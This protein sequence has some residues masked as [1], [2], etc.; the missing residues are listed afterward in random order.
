MEL[1]IE[2]GRAILRLHPTVAGVA[3]QILSS[4][5]LPDGQWRVE[6][7]VTGAHDWTLATLPWRGRTSLFLTARSAWPGGFRPADGAQSNGCPRALDAML[8]IDVS[9]SLSAGDFQGAMEAADN[10]VALVDFSVDRVGLVSFAGDARLDQSL[11]NNGT[12]VRT[13]ILGLETRSGT[14]LHPAIQAAQSNLVGS[15]GSV[16][17]LM[18]LLSDGIINH[19]PAVNTNLAKQE[20]A[21]A[22]AAGTRLISIAYGTDPAGTNL[23]R[24]L[25]SGPQDFYY[26]PSAA[27]LRARFTAIAASLCRDGTTNLPPWVRLDTPTHQSFF[28][29]LAVPV[30]ASAMDEDGTIVRLDVVANGQVIGSGAGTNLSFTWHPTGGGTYVLSAHATDDK[31]AVAMSP[32]ATI[33]I[34]GGP[35]VGAGPDQTVMMAGSNPVSA[36]LNGTVDDPDGLPLGRMLDIQWNVQGGPG[37]VALEPDPA[38]PA[39]AARARATFRIPGVY[40]LRL[41]VSDSLLSR[42]DEVRITVLKTNAPPVVWT[43]PS[44]TILHPDPV[45]LPGAVLDDGAPVGGVLTA[46]WGGPAGVEFMNPYVTNTFARFPGPGVYPLLL[47]AWDGMQDQ[48]GL[49]ATGRVT[50]TVLPARTPRVV[51]DRDELSVGVGG[52][53]GFFL[54]ESRVSDANPHPGTAELWLRGL[55]G[56][57]D[58]AF[59][60]WHG[61]VDPAAPSVNAAVTI[62]G[63]LIT[64]QDLGR[65]RDNGWTYQDQSHS[66]AYSRAY[67]ADVT[68][69]VRTFGSGPYMLTNF[70]KGAEVEVN[71]ASMVVFFDDGQSGNNHDFILADGNDSNDSLNFHPATPVNFGALDAAPGAVKALALA[72]DGVFIAGRFISANVP[73]RNGIARLRPGGALDAAFAPVAGAAPMGDLREGVVYQLNAMALQRDGKVILGGNFQKIEGQARTN[74]ARLLPDGKLD[75]SF[76]I[77]VDGPVH[78]LLIDGNGRIQVGGGFATVNGLVR[79]S[80]AR[81]TSTGALDGTFAPALAVNGGSIFALAVQTNGQIVVGGDF[82]MVNGMARSGVARLDP[83]GTLDPDFQP[84]ADGSVRALLVRGNGQIVLGGE[85]SHVDQQP[86]TGVALLNPDGTLDPGFQ[87]DLSGTTLDPIRTVHLGLP[88]VEALAEHQGRILI[89]GRFVRVNGQPRGRIARLLDDGSPDSSFNPNPGPDTAVEDG[90]NPPDATA[91]NALA[92]QPDGRILIGGC[93]EAWNGEVAARA[94][95][96]LNADGSMDTSFRVTDEG[97]SMTV[98]DLDYSSGEASLEVHV[99]DGQPA[100]PVEVNGVTVWAGRQD[101]SLYINSEL[102]IAPAA[103]VSGN[104]RLNDRQVF[105]GVSVP[106]AFWPPDRL[107]GLWDILSKPL[108]SALLRPGL[109][110]LTLRAGV[111]TQTSLPEGDGFMDPDAISLVAALARLPVGQ[112]R[113]HPEPPVRPP[114]DLPPVAWTDRFQVRR[115]VGRAVLDVLG[116]DISPGGRLLTLSAVSQPVSGTC[117]IIQ[118]GSAILYVAQPG[119]ASSAAF[120]YTVMDSSGNTAKATVLIQLL[121]STDATALQAG[122]PI[123]GSLVGQLA[124]AKSGSYPQ[125]RGPYV[126]ATPYVGGG[127]GDVPVGGRDGVPGL[128]SF[129]RNAATDTNSTRDEGQF[130]AFYIFKAR[131]GERLSLILKTTNFL[132]HLYLRDPRGQLIASSSHRHYV[133]DP[134]QG[135]PNPV[136]FQ[137]IRSNVLAQPAPVSGD[138]TLEVTTHAP[139]ETGPYTLGLN[140]APPATPRLELTV[141]GIALANGQN[142][143]LGLWPSGT[144]T[145]LTLRNVGEI[146][147]PSLTIQLHSLEGLYDSTVYPTNLADLRAGQSAALTWSPGRRSGAGGS[148]A[149][150]A[151]AIDTPSG[152]IFQVLLQGQFNPPG[153]GPLGVF[154][155]ETPASGTAFAPLATIPVTV[156]VEPNSPHPFDIPLPVELFALSAGRQFRLGD[157]DLPDDINGSFNDYTFHWRNVPEGLHQLVARTRVDDFLVL[158]EPV[159]V[160][161]QQP[162]PN[163]RPLA[164]NDLVI[165]T[166]NSRNNTLHLL[167]NDADPDLDPLRITTVAA[168]GGTATTDG[169]AVRYTPPP[170]ARGTDIITYEVS[171]GRGGTARALATVHIV[172]DPIRLLS[173]TD[174]A[175]YRTNTPVPLQALASTPAGAISRVEFL[176]DGV[177]VAQSRATAGSLYTN[178]WF[179]GRAGYYTLTAAAIDSSGARLV[180]APV[181][182]IVNNTGLPSPDSPPVAIVA[183]VAENQFVRDGF[184]DVRGTAT[185]TDGPAAYQLTVRR[186]SDESVLAILTGPDPV[187]EGPLGRLDLTLLRNGSYIL[188]LKVTEG[189]GES[190][191]RVPFLLDNQAKA[192]QLA[193]AEQDLIVPIAGFPITVIRSYDS[194]N[195]NTGDF[196]PGWTMALHDLEMEIDEVRQ[197][198]PP[199]QDNTDPDDL[200]PLRVGGGR[201]ISLTLPDGRRT[202]FAYSV[203]PGSS[204]DG[205]PCFCYRARWTPP[206]G[207]HAS[208]TPLDRDT[209]TFIP[210]QSAIDPY[211]DAAGLNTSLDNF[212]FSGFVLTNADG[213]RFDLE[214]PR[215]GLVELPSDGEGALAREAVVRGPA[216]LARIIKTTGERLE[217]G[218]EGVRHFHAGRTNR[219]ASLYFVRDPLRPQLI[220]AIHAPDTLDPGGRPSPDALPA[221]RYDYYPDEDPA[222]GSLLRVHRLVDRTRPPALAY[223]T[224]LYLYTDPDHPRLLTSVI[225]TNHLD[226]S[227][228]QVRHEFDAAGR[229]TGSAD[230]AGAHARLQH[231][232]GSRRAVVTDA[233]GHSSIH[234]Y[235]PR[236]NVTRSIDALGRAVTRA[237]DARDNLLSETDPLGN[238]LSYACDARGNR[239]AATNALGHVS[240]FAYDTFDR[241]LAVV[242]AR[243][244]GVTNRYDAQGNLTHTV[245]A[246]GQQTHFLYDDRGQLVS[247]TDALGTFTTNH[248]DSQGRLTLAATRSP[249]LETLNSASYTYDLL[250]RRLTESVAYTDTDGQ[251]R[252]LVTAHAYDQQGRPIRTTNDF[253]G[254]NLVSAQSY[255]AFGRMDSTTDA[256][257]RVTRYFFD[258]PGNRVQT[259]LCDGD[260]T[261]LSVTRT[262]FDE[263]HRPLY[264][265]D[266]IDVPPGFNPLE[267]P[268]TAN[269]TRHVYDA[270]GRVVRTERLHAATLTPVSGEGALAMRFDG[271]GR[272]VEDDEGHL[273][274]VDE[275][276]SATSTDYDEAGR[277]RATTNTRGAT[278]RYDYDAAGRRTNVVDALGQSMRYTYDAA[279]NLSVATDAL[280]RGATNVYDALGR[281]ISRLQPDG[282]Q[283]RTLYDTLG[284]SVGEV[285]A[286]G[287]TNRFGYDALGRLVAATNA[288]ATPAAT[289]TT[290][291]H[292]ELGRQTAQT[293]AL[294][295]VTRFAYDALGRRIKRTLPGGQQESFAYDASGN[296]I[297]HTHFNGLVITNRYNPQNR[298]LSRH[299]APD[300]AVLESFTY[301]PTGHRATMTDPSGLTMFRYDPADRLA[302]NATPQGELRYAYNP[303]G[304][305]TNLQTST[306]GGAAVTYA[307]D[308]LGRLTS[309]GNCPQAAGPLAAGPPAAGPA[310]RYTYD[311][312]GN[313][314]TVAYANG[315]QHRYRHDLMNRLTNLVMATLVATQATFAYRLD[316]TGH[317]TNLVETLNAQPSTLNRIYS[318]RYDPLHRLTNETI[319]PG[320]AGVSP[321]TLAYTY[322]PVGN[323]LTRNSELGTLN[324]QSLSYGSN[325]WLTSDTYDANGNTETG[326][327]S[328]GAAIHCL[329]DWANRL[330]NAII[331]SKTIALTYN[332][333][334][335]RVK[336]VVTETGQTTTTCYLVDDHNPTGYAQVVEEHISLD[337]QPSTLNRVYTYGLDLLSQ[338]T[339]NPQPSTV[340]FGYDGHGSTRLLTDTNGAITA[341][342]TYDAFGTLI[343]STPDLIPQTLY[344]YAGEQWDPDLALYYNRARYLNPDTA[345]FWSMDTHEGNSQDPLS[346]HKYLYASVDPVNMVDPSGHDFTI[347]GV[348][349][350]AAWNTYWRGGVANVTAS[351]VLSGLL[352]QGYSVAEGAWDFVT[353]GLMGGASVVVSSVAKALSAKIG[354]RIIAHAVLQFGPPAVNAA[355][356]T[357]EWA[358]R[359]NVVQHQ[360]VSVAE[361]M[362][363]FGLTTTANYILHQG[364]LMSEQKREAAR[365]ILEEIQQLGNRT[366]AR[367]F[368]SF[369]HLWSGLNPQTRKAL[370]DWAQAVESNADLP[371]YIVIMGNIFEELVGDIAEEAGDDLGDN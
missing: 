64:G 57:V 74:V 175:V 146:D 340:F 247:Q 309:V 257:G 350:S 338:S 185:D 12:A 8:V 213:T 334:G 210:W 6:Q 256:A 272:F 191:A 60:Y 161:V 269:A 365:R 251:P 278:T 44:Q 36:L 203:V 302:T 51:Q 102:W 310:A 332:A 266:R 188:E 217:F 209:I 140:V 55:A 187:S 221:L 267:H 260:G 371:V 138:Y 239:T 47:R 53:R 230:S 150:L 66:F 130:A 24:D 132:S 250:G 115:G 253:G 275:F 312:V 316:P 48:G 133:F 227:S 326:R 327:Q 207:V 163:R 235:D 127:V 97:W 96:R 168:A 303:A 273:F 212:D 5:S 370:E 219:T 357:S 77:R 283:T 288:W 224:T 104:G 101:P 136:P 111:I 238:T 345:R 117:E 159:V 158:S 152:R 116:N 367:G 336:K 202:T 112:T 121:G 119:A 31:G 347:A 323:R 222:A 274:R 268:T 67:R 368:G 300:G 344:L 232:P 40:S 363:V 155:I 290:Y 286:A 301:N 360:E 143:D 252:T 129:P 149:S 244:F 317:R 349:A 52:M 113:T 280:G 341:T 38:A 211:W 330:T 204:D 84:A 366:T 43:G 193:F 254:A 196:G 255:D 197:W 241:V 362:W 16:L 292:D 9:R 199:D 156:R 137:L 182:V 114:S 71:G 83:D 179:P 307:Y 194:L 305:L 23:M 118:S 314:S 261:P 80:L 105:A 33:T 270:L 342:Y 245:D 75:T 315:L 225:V 164:S 216:K 200:L 98:P 50:I 4:E 364:A 92:V 189:F 218:S 167:A 236:G 177:R 32:G 11:T 291:A 321:A 246:L 276:I 145:T 190:L 186:P 165:V 348:S 178:E 37:P 120:T 298:L 42:A 106:S 58:R 339:L 320:D 1:G 174:L 240:R 333:D 2:N 87:A 28:P 25:A 135:D 162:L 223:D 17:P 329:Y 26:A 294:G 126:G 10:F 282:R 208:L 39:A 279:G 295:R 358:V 88:H 319:T 109:A 324:S 231:E 103:V 86:R 20:A 14:L 100:R 262:V 78:A 284:R 355:I 325:D 198:T 229:W 157:L 304:L 34:N 195:P 205:V 242:D 361:V 299:A 27:E 169:A 369:R 18:L 206:P 180:S 123:S 285:D 70:A 110:S 243:G 297:A 46:R 359:K 148:M 337:S 237:Y 144:P 99:S 85:F 328:A 13:H 90:G 76:N 296:V 139:G 214:A 181:R 49:I 125:G 30:H 153:P 73:G 356:S 19:N 54:N 313:L 62:N 95:A 248:Y 69:L 166:V 82:S 141:E 308:A 318:W 45:Y 29:G 124:A 108:P 353:G 107:A 234:E 131:A 306:P 170:N 215:L 346:L 72:A 258:I 233:L 147:L 59:L 63:R 3:Y 35:M 160:R 322:D 184:L 68:E 7:E 142:A 264:T 128:N 228:R 287:V 226:G 311:G 56:R 122:P 249:E 335:Q 15:G 354:M 277:V 154:Q 61:P 151:L 331:G 134:E 79:R 22:K 281:L 259:V 289:W 176:A 173:P 271:A 172:A 41:T 81:L 171:D 343:A 351:L 91:I 183:N 293:D 220:T 265:Q 93:F 263:L 94:V 201:N 352:N 21:A 65:S 192:G 89:G